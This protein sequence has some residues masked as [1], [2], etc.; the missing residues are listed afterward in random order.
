M[1]HGYSA[2]SNTVYSGEINI[3]DWGSKSDAEESH[4]GSLQPAES[5]G[6]TGTACI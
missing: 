1:L 2:G 4:Q 3:T 5:K 6:R